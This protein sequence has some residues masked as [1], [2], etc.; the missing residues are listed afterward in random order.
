MREKTACTVGGRN[1]DFHQIFLYENRTIGG[2]E[3]AG[4]HTV[5]LQGGQQLPA[6][7]EISFYPGGQVR[8]LVLAGDAVLA[9]S[10]GLSL[11]KDGLLS[12]HEN[13][14]VK[15][16]GK[17]VKKEIRGVMSQVYEY[18]PLFGPDGKVFALRRLEDVYV[19]LGGNMIVIPAGRFVI[20]RDEKNRIAGGVQIGWRQLPHHITLPDLDLQ[21]FG[22]DQVLIFA[23]YREDGSREME[24][25]LFTQDL[26][27]ER[28]GRPVSCRAFE[29]IHV[30][31]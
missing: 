13:G 20:Y 7:R 5:I 1:Y 17:W 22:K 3:L 31:P 10:P 24:S 16:Y 28:G 30:A 2:G 14:R 6:Y 25:L 18:S 23:R 27:M 29:W 19:R 12:L 11:K 21:R 9:G 15:L 8:T 26:V 4:V